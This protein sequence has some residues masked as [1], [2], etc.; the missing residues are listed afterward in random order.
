[1]IT[2]KSNEAM[3]HVDYVEDEGV[4]RYNVDDADLAHN[5]MPLPLLMEISAQPETGITA[6]YKRI[7]REILDGLAKAG[8]KLNWSLVPGGPEYGF[9]G[10]LF[11]KAASGTRTF[12]L[13]Y[14][15]CF[16]SHSPLVLDVGCVQ[17]IL[18]GKVKVKSGSGVSEMAEDGVILEDRTRLSADVVIFA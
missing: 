6:G 8:F 16:S 18:D 10:I 9:V 15:S 2:E 13:F 17:L 11:Q 3:A 12:H 1:V 4:P 14:E 7:D 5:S